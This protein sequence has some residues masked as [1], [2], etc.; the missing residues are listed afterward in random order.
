MTIGYDTEKKVLTSV[1]T[2]ENTSFEYMFKLC[3]D[4]IKQNENTAKYEKILL[5]VARGLDYEE[6]N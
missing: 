1:K 5:D 3:I 2:P 4:K 6:K